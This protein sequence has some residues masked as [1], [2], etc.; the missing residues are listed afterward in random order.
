M[1]GDCWWKEGG[2]IDGDR[3]TNDPARRCDISSDRLFEI[4]AWV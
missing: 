3:A 4:V 2:Y 1:L